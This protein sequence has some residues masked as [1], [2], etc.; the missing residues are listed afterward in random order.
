[1]NAYTAQHAHLHPLVIEYTWPALFN[2]S[3]ARSRESSPQA[4]PMKILVV[5]DHPLIQEALRHALPALQSEV[6]LLDAPDCASA[7]G[8]SNLHP[9]L[10]LIL[11][12]LQL[13]DIQGLDALR[14]IRMSA[15]AT[16]IVVLSGTEDSSVVRASLE[17]GA[18]GFIPKSSSNQVLLNALRLVMSGGVYVPPQAI[19]PQGEVQTRNGSAGIPAPGAGCAASELGLTERQAE[20]L[21]LMVEGLPNKLICRRLNLAEGTVKIHVTAILKA[22]NVQSRTQAVI[23]ANRLGLRLPRVPS[24]PR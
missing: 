23:E 3:A 17:A 1:M 9:D 12:D 4:V 11:L 14:Q 19:H 22:L 15:P 13:P 2:E 21:S 7:I 24:A 18:M 16:P 20:V 5:D 8:L 10:D 6:T